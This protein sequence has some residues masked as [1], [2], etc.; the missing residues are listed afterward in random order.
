[1]E[2][3]SRRSPDQLCGRLRTNQVVNFPGPREWIGSLV[4]LQITEAHPHS[5]KGRPLEV[6]LT[7][8]PLADRL[9]AS[10]KELSC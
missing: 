6:P 10:P 3:L 2:G 9:P 8:Q 7:S 5:L 1:M 4:L